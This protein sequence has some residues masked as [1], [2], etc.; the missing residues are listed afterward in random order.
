[1]EGLAG[2]AGPGQGEFC[3]VAVDG[4]AAGVDIAGEGGKI[5]GFTDKDS[6]ALDAAVVAIFDAAAGAFGDGF[7]WAGGDKSGTVVEH[8]G[9]ILFKL[10]KKGE[11]VNYWKK[12][13][14]LG[15]DSSTLEQKIAQ[16]KY[17]E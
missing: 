16:E 3:A 17:I 10:G 13:K 15:T 4:E 14:E 12:A 7:Q 11:A 8:Y 9:D 5:V 2:R 1:M 6:P